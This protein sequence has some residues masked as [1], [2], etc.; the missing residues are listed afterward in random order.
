MFKI[1]KYVNVPVFVLS[2]AIGL[3]VVYMITEDNRIIHIYP[4]PENQELLL[5][6][7]K[8]HQCFTFENKEIPCPTNPLDIS[9]I[10]VQG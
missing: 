1:S 4:T 6:R 2:F 3:L 10:P 8:A 9:K 7:D 5:Y